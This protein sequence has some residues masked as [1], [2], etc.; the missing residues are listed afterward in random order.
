MKLVTQRLKLPSTW[1]RYLMSKP[2]TGMGFQSVRVTLRSGVV[3]DDVTAWNC[4]ILSMNDGSNFTFS[5]NEI[6]NIEVLTKE[7]NHA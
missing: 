4:E 3:V 1:F 5:A 6:E 2:E 7:G